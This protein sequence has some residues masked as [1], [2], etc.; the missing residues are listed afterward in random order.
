MKRVFLIHNP[1]A[2]RASDRGRDAI[3]GVLESDGLRVSVGVIAGPG[4]ATVLAREAVGEA[5]DFV[6]VYGG[7]G[8]V[9]HAA[10]GMLGSGVPLA[11]IPGGTGNLLAGNLRIP[12]NPVKAAR[13]VAVGRPRVIDVGRLETADG[14]TC[15][16]VA[17]GAGYDAELM[18]G[19]TSTAKRRWGM[20]AYVAHVVR[21]AQRIRRAPFRVIVDGATHDFKAASVLVANC[22]EAIPPILKLGPEVAPDDGVLDVVVLKGEGFLGAARVVWQLLRQVTDGELIDRLRGGEIRVEADE[23]QPV[24]RDGEIGGTTPFTVKV[25]RGALRVIAPPPG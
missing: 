17:C 5:N 21:T 22:R 13:L 23:P 19:T 8:T 15:F 11:L 20:G 25:V 7:D 12:R 18:M 16:T 14:T 9:M 6:A 2:A 1:L 3:V 4:D 10:E 24:E